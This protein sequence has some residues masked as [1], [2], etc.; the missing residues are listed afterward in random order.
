[1]DAF[2]VAHS[3]KNIP[4]AKNNDFSDILLAKTEDFL[5]RIRWKMYFHKNPNENTSS[6]NNYGFKSEV[7]PPADDD[8]S[9]F[10]AD[11]MHMAANVK[12]RKIEKCSNPL[13]KSMEKQLSDIRK[14][15]KL[16]IQADKTTNLYKLDRITYDKMLSD[17]ITATYKKDLGST[18][19]EVNK[20]ASAI[21]TS[22]GLQERVYSFMEKCPRITLKDH[23]E[24]FKVRPQ[25]RLLNPA[26]TNIGRI[27]KK[28]LEKIVLEIRNKTKL[29]LW[30]SNN[31]VLT[32]FKDLGNK[33]SL[34]FLKYDICE[35]YPSIS[36]E[37]LLK[38]LAWAKEFVDIS[39]LDIAIILHSRKSFL[40]HN[41]STLIKSDTVNN[42]DCPMGSLDL[43]LK[44]LKSL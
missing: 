14:N 35:Y 44:G 2:H 4:I 24:N 39:D 9:G 36:E 12:F 15:D 27:S 40:F 10:E 38:A 25:V 43:S 34:K 28:I 42:F 26:S 30:R 20:E 29:P 31:D 18:I 17:N 32:W 7:T 8:L 37:L 23:K 33:K 11:L 22:L 6:K 1:M 16:V 5:R 21:A 19:G 3:L 41:G 13:Q